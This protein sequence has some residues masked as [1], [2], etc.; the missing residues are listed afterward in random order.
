MI[1]RASLIEL[2]QRIVKIATGDKDKIYFN[3]EDNDYPLTIRLAIQNSPTASRAHRLAT[4]FIAGSEL[5]K[6]ADFNKQKTIIKRKDQPVTNEKN[7]E[8]L[9]DLKDGISYDLAEQGGCFIHVTKKLSEDGKKIENDQFTILDYAKCRI[10]KAD[11]DENAGKVYFG[12][13]SAGIKGGLGKKKK[14]YV[15]Y[16]PYSNNQ[17]VV[18]AQIESQYDGDGDFVDAVKEFKGQVLYV[19]ST[20]RLIYALAP[21]DPVFN[22][23]DT[24]YRISVYFNEQTRLGFMGKTAVIV[25]GGVDEDVRAQ[26]EESVEGFLGVEG[27]SPLWLMQ[28]TNAIE[29]LDQVVKFI[30]IPNNVDEKFVGRITQYLED[31]I[32]GAFF[33][34]PGGLVLTTDGA[35]FSPSGESISELKKFYSDATSD[36]RDLTERTLHTLGFTDYFIQE[37]E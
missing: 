14:D 37:V 28:L 5:Y 30:Q 29:N 24:E 17:K 22:N 2:Y 9:C 20:P 23:C 6:T 31:S 15:E 18:R 3:G 33:N 13:F 1:L 8:K 25:N 32:L 19:N 16:L 11:D 10:S 27:S 21:V 12:D 7:D 36:M 26:I 34:L 35:L 4:T